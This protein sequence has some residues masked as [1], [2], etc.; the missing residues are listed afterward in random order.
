[1]DSMRHLSTSL[2]RNRSEPPNDLLND[3]KAAARSVTDLYRTAATSQKQSRAAGYQDALDDLLSFL[4]KENLGLMDGEGWRV[5]QWATERL[6]GEGA[7]ASVSASLTE[8]DDE[9]RSIKEED[10]EDTRSSSPEV[11][12]RP[13]QLP[14]LSSEVA[15]HDPLNSRRVVS[16]P[17]TAPPYPIHQ[18]LPQADFTFQSSHSYPSGNHD[19][20]MEV[21]NSTTSSGTQPDAETIRF[22]PRPARPTR[23][24]RR[25][26][27]DTRT[28]ALN[29]GSG[30]GSKRKIPYPDLFDISGINDVGDRRDNNAPGRGGKRRHV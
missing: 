17:P 24:N 12:R 27:T 29:L 9:D 14:V 10:K 18:A 16:E 7:P 5:R 20:D 22:L 4:D 6:D 8:Q 21:D 30:A 26:G 15:E 1:M 2:P 19:R 3:F 11:Q 23:H 13:P 28:P 25:N